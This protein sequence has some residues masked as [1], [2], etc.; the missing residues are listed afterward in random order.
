[1]SLTKWRCVSD[2]E[3]SETPGVGFIFVQTGWL[4][5]DGSPQQRGSGDIHRAN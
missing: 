2:F 3:E 4:G 1:M 5:S